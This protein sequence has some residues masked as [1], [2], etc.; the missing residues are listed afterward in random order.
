MFKIIWT[1]PDGRLDSIDRETPVDAMNE[2]AELLAQGLENVTIRDGEGNAYAPAYFRKHFAADNDEAALQL[3]ADAR[4]LLGEHDF[5]GAERVT[6]AA[7]RLRHPASPPN[8]K[9]E[10]A[11]PPV[12]TGP[13]T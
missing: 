4:R 2:A 5:A 11:T 12:P 6:R 1:A 10:G 3:L 13:A 8:I 7:I 9:S